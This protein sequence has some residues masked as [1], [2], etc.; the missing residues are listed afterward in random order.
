MGVPHGD[1]LGIHHI[2]PHH[3]PCSRDVHT[4]NTEEKG[5]YVDRLSHPICSDLSPVRLRK[6][7]GVAQYCASWTRERVALFLPF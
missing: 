7:A 1:M 2:G 3:R 6:E 4:S 5:S